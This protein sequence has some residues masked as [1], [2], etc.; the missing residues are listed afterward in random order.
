[1]QNHGSIFSSR[2]N[3]FLFVYIEKTRAKCFARNA[4]SEKLFNFRAACNLTT[5]FSSL[6]TKRLKKKERKKKDN[7]PLGKRDV[8]CKKS[9]MMFSNPLPE[10]P[11]FRL[12]KSKARRVPREKRKQ[13]EN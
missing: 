6:F 12:C 1:M 9:F 13:K 2:L 11:R 10:R 4:R 7:K 3:A 8:R 5:A